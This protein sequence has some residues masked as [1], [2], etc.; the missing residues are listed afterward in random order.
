MA[1]VRKRNEILKVKDDLVNHYLTIGYD[2]VDEN[3]AVLKKAV[4]NDTIQLKGEFQRLTLENEQL[5]EQ[6]AE[7]EAKLAE[8]T[9][10]KRTRKSAEE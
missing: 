2:V 10:P 3:G 1:I 8:A 6:I 4:P 5:K 9:K 7:L